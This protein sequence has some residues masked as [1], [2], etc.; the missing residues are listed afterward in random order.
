M[1]QVIRHITQ[2]R[3]QDYDV[4]NEGLKQKENKLLKLS[5]TNLKDFRLPSLNPSQNVVDVIPC[6]TY[7]VSELVFVNSNVPNW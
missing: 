1:C 4:H 6:S 5:D 3:G 7:D 2:Q